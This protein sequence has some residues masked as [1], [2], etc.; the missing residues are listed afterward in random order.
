MWNREVDRAIVN[1]VP[2]NEIRHIKK[3]YITDRIRQSVKIWGNRPD[4]FMNIILTATDVLVALI[5]KVFRAAMELKD[6]LFHEALEKEYGREI[7][8]D[9]EIKEM[10]NNL[11]F[12]YVLPRYFQTILPYKGLYGRK[13]HSAFYQEMLSFPYPLLIIQNRIH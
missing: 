12:F 7:D 5:S 11:D 10:L 1:E 13:T 4:K 6:K 3:E 8:F 2:E 9:K